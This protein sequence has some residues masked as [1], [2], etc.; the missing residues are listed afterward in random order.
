M[1]EKEIVSID[2]NVFSKEDAKISVFDHCLLYGDGVFEG[3]RIIGNKV[4]LL[5]S[6][7][8]R[9]YASAKNIRLKMPFEKEKMKGQI[10][11][12]CK[13]SGIENGYIRLVMTR[14]IGDLGINPAKCANGKTIII[15][16]KLALYPEE[17]Y[18][19]GLKVVFTPTRKISVQNWNGR[20]KS[21]NYLNNI[22]A[23]WEFLDGNAD[24]GIMLDLNGYVSEATVD[25]VFAIRGNKLFTPSLATN[26]LEGIT[27]NAVME[28]AKEKGMEVE[29]GFYVYH[30]FITADEIFLTGTGAGIIPVTKTNTAEISGGKIGEKTRALRSA[31]EARIKE[32]GTQI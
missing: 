23:T 19:N 15:V 7:I 6:H 30:D 14:G 25:N 13:E 20:V 28:I 26:C 21:C 4:I 16:A 32:T 31:Y 29:E 12:A 24:E 5:D 18:E 27:R 9:L 22:M 17:R 1:A 8:D 3:I 2:G 10:L 11:K